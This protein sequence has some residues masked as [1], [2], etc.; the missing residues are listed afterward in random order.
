[1]DSGGAIPAAELKPTALRRFQAGHQRIK[2]NLVQCMVKIGV[3][4]NLLKYVF[5][6]PAFWKSNRIAAWFFL[7]QTWLIFGVVSIQ[8]L[9]HILRF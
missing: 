7:A 3:I 1:M 8:E 5:K 6:T 4:L 9:V 2:I